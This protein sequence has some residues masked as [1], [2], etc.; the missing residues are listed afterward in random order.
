[1]KNLPNF[2]IIGPPKSASTSL[3]FYL[4]Q[5]PEIFVSKI[6]ETN[7]FTHDYEKGLDYYTTFFAGSEYAKAIGEATPAY[8]FL[9]FVADRIQQNLPNVKFIIVAR[10]PIERAFS[11]WLMLWEAG[12]EKIPFRQ[13]VKINLEQLLYVNFEN[14]KGAQLWEERRFMN[15]DD[16]NWSRTYL[17]PGFYAKNLE[18]Y[19]K[20]FSPEQIKL[21]FLEDLNSNFDATMENL[22][23]FLK[24]DKNFIVSVK[25]EMNVYFN[26]KYFRLLQTVIGY[27]AAKSISKKLPTGFKTL[28]K[29][30]K[31]SVKNK[32]VISKED[33]DFVYEVYQKDIEQ[34]EHLTGKKLEHWKNATVINTKS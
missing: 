30:K 6:K 29:Q 23:A 32:P 34:L 26:K 9:P 27:K 21:V 14:E 10:N 33:Y 7:F 13:A 17:Q 19:Y 8:C 11:N 22:F 15:S 2:L 5:H 1:M 20:R 28:L 3:H 31:N 4:G 18:M 16:K 12:T 25:D 24:V